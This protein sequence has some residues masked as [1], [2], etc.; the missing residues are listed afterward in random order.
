LAEHRSRRIWTIDAVRGLAIFGVVIF[1]LVWD[2]EFAGFIDG[3]ARHPA[4][5]VF[6]RTLAGT[7]IALVGVSLVLAHPHGVRWRPA[8]RRLGMIA[9]AAAAITAVTRLTF[10]DAFVYFGILHA[11]AAATL[12]GVLFLQARALVAFGAGV[13]IFALP[14]VYASPVFDTRWLAWIGFA[15]KP[16]LSND[17]VPI[18]P[19][20]GLTLLAIAGTKSAAAFGIVQWIADHERRGGIMK[21]LGWMGRHSLA[22]YLIHQP[23]LLAIILPL[24]RLLP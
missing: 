14:L 15:A 10:P 21:T 2:L 12:I 24:A 11:I 20:V 17:F 5:L 4:W 16:P 1:H 22:I 6:G 13:A 7:F 23:V 18:F 8:L 3:I 19:W 9:L